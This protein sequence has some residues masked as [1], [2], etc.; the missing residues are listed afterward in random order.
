MIPWN[1]FEIMRTVSCILGNSWRCFY[2]HAYD[3]TMLIYFFVINKI[4]WIIIYFYLSPKTLIFKLNKLNAKCIV[5]NVRTI[6]KM[7][8]EESHWFSNQKGDFQFW[9]AIFNFVWKENFWSSCLEGHIELK[10]ASNLTKKS[11]ATR[12][13]ANNV[14]VCSGK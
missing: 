13:F 2:Q 12:S 7:K 8:W 4:E 9:W 10:F 3:M 11:W 1:N 5:F 14:S 6:L